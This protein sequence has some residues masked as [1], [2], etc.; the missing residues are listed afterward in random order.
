M[1]A[2][3]HTAAPEIAARPASH[4]V[5]TL[6]VPPPVA[7]APAAQV[8][9]VS[10]PAPEYLPAAQ[11][12]QRGP[13]EPAYMPPGHDAQAKASDMPGAVLALPA[14]QPVQLVPPE[15]AEHGP[16]AQAR[17]LPRLAPPVAA[18]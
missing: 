10:A 17:Q 4:G 13:L 8:R 15:T 11:L 2:L 1:S 14:G 16:A 3:P 5:H 18:E 7:Y 12:T 6:K 9:H